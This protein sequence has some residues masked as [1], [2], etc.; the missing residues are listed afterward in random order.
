MRCAP[1]G[2]SPKSPNNVA[3]ARCLAHVARR[4][5]AAGVKVLFEAKQ[6]ELDSSRYQLAIRDENIDVRLNHVADRGFARRF[7]VPQNLIR[8]V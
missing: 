1:I 3:E 5:D 4:V 8:L 6:E 7:S 2:N